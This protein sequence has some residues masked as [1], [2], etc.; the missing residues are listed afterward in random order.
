MDA[1]EAERGSSWNG[2]EEV[3]SLSMSV[4]GKLELGSDEERAAPRC[5]KVVASSCQR[6]DWSCPICLNDVPFV[7]TAIVKDCNHLFCSTCILNWVLFKQESSGTKEPRSICPTCR[8]PFDVVGTYRRLDG[9]LS[10]TLVEESIYLLLRAD[11]FDCEKFVKY[12]KGKKAAWQ[13]SHDS[14]QDQVGLSMSPTTRK[15]Y[16]ADDYLEAAYE[17]EAF[18]EDDD[19]YY[20]HDEYS[21]PG[22]NRRNGGG[23]SSSGAGCS[24]SKLVIGNRRWGQ[25]G[26][27]T[28]GRM[29][30]RP[31]S[32]G[33]GAG[34]S[35]SGKGKGKKKF[36]QD[37]E[38]E[39]PYKPR[40]ESPGAK[41]TVGR[42]ARRAM[43][44]KGAAKNALDRALC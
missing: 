11:W 44:N 5:E 1:R 3:R 40:Y 38:E 24:T 9:S 7:E 8:N 35:S 29:Y 14:Q 15:L 13:D 33:G 6:S 26:Y 37:G 41:K 20:G 25:Q 39:D 10:D 31:S 36:Q 19:Y 43:K 30:A 23:N 34:S 17:E 28:S 2:E 27:V 16:G 18:E 12:R 42:R 4:E 22:G 21:S 32:S